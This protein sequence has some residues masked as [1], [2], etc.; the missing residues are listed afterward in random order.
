MNNFDTPS[1][2][3]NIISLQ[4]LLDRVDA[5]DDNKVASY[6]GTCILAND[7]NLSLQSDTGRLLFYP[8]R[9]EAT[10][11]IICQRGHIKV[12]CNLQ[13][14]VISADS[15]FICPP[16]TIVQC[17]DIEEGVV[18]IMIAS[19]RLFDQ[20]N[21][22]LIKLIP[23]FMN[24]SEHNHFHISHNNCQQLVHL[25]QAAKEIVV[26]EKESIFYEEICDAAL[27]TLQ[28][29]WLSILSQYQSSHHEDV[30]RLTRKEALFKDFISQ[31]SLDFMRERS[32]KY[33]AD[34]MCISPKYLGV[35]VKEVSGQNANAII[36]HCVIAEAKNLLKYSEM[37]I[38]QVS[39]HLNFSNQSFFGKYFKKHTGLSPMEFR[40]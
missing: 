22:R 8:T 21:P 20:L 19:T 9:L 14:F 33:Y 23:Q 2:G 7:L 31:V 27:M 30:Q 4:Y 18:S 34:K 39:Q 10:A 1:H 25:I 32:L 5:H 15:I 40:K 3:L 17:L 16:G 37:S 26:G 11:L 13:D 6:K 38:Q 29:K 35:I 28:Y 36:D 12:N 24:M